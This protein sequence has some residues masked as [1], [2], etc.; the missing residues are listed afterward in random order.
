[1]WL[2]VERLVWHIDV[3]GGSL[4][5]IILPSPGWGEGRGQGQTI[6]KG[7]SGSSKLW[8]ALV[9]EHYGVYKYKILGIMRFETHFTRVTVIFLAPN[10]SLSTTSL[11]NSQGSVWASWKHPVTQLPSLCLA[12]AAAAE[13]CCL[14]FKPWLQWLQRIRSKLQMKYPNLQPCQE[15]FYFFNLIQIQK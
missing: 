9:V 12:A 10:G 15:L 2:L 1:M 6:L 5:F 4:G 13:L 14:I 8:K 3:W 7:E 11:H